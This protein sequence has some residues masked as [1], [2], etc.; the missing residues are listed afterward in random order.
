ML[1]ELQTSTTTFGGEETVEYGNTLFWDRSVVFAY[2][3]IIK[4]I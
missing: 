2:G 3:V 1:E 4:E